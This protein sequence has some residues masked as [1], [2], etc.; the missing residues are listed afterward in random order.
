MYRQQMLMAPAP[1]STNLKCCWAPALPLKE[2][3]TSVGLRFLDNFWTSYCL[4]FVD[5]HGGTGRKPPEWVEN[6]S[7]EPSRPQPRNGHSDVAHQEM[8]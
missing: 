1:N 4:A 7:A 3:E 8:I 2:T 5:L 6:K